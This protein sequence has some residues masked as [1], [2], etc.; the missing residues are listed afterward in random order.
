MS[1]T[2]KKHAAFSLMEIMIAVA[3]IGVMAAVV[4]PSIIKY[5]SKGKETATVATLS[6]LKQAVQDYMNDVGH[7]PNKKEGGLEALI[8]QP[9]M[10]K[11]AK[12]WDGPYL[13]GQ[14]DIPDDSWGNE[15]VYNTGKD[16]MNK[17]KYR[18]FEIIS[19]GENGD[20]E[21]GKNF[22]IGA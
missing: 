20:I 12:R 21:E 2:Y 16:I 4:G 7:V 17:K 10:A 8:E 19:G 22:D 1:T 9:K 15:F 5:L 14:E 13:D 11:I 3:I 6:S 18:Y